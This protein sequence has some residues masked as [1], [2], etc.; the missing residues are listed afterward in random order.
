MVRTQSTTPDSALDIAVEEREAWRRRLTI[1][2]D[3]ARVAR[4]RR[5]ERDRL[6]GKLRLKGFR[7]GKV[8]KAVVEQRY[9]E[10]VD[11]RTVQRL[12]EDAYREAVRRHHLEPIGAPEFGEVRYARG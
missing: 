11:Q 5:K 1:T 9:G 8:P 10:L 7:S 3:A 6:S 4:A 2:V 12:V